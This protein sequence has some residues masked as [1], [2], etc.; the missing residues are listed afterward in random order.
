MHPLAAVLAVLALAPEARALEVA[1]VTLAPTASLGGRT[2]VLNG[3]GLRKRVF[4]KVYVGGLYVEARSS[5]PEA[6]V[7]ADQAKLVRMHFLRDVDRDSILG[8]FREGFRNNSPATAAEA[9]ARLAEVEKVL[10]AEVKKGQVLVVSYLPGAG[11]AVGIEGGPS[12]AVEGKAFADALFRNWLGPQ[13][14][15]A[16]LKDGMLGK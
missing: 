11:S 10:P 6:L 3:A 16:D 5:D 9:T 15:D 1:G 14:A 12:A 7:A 13:P 4:F 2:L 8:A